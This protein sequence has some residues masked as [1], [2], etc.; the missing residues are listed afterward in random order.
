ML[1]LFPLADDLL[2]LLPLS[3]AINSAQRHILIFRAVDMLCD[4]SEEN[5][6]SEFEKELAQGFV[7]ALIY[8]FITNLHI[9]RY[10]ADYDHMNSTSL[11]ECGKRVNLD[12]VKGVLPKSTEL[13]TNTREV[14]NWQA[15][16]GFGVSIH[17][18]SKAYFTKP[19]LNEILNVIFSGEMHK[20]LELKNV[21][22]LSTNHLP[23][24][25][26]SIDR[27]GRTFFSRLLGSTNHTGNINLLSNEPFP[28]NVYRL[29]LYVY[30]SFSIWNKAW[31]HCKNS[32]VHNRSDIRKIFQIA[33]MNIKLTEQDFEA[34]LNVISDFDLKAR[35]MILGNVARTHDNVVDLLISR[36]P[37]ASAP[38]SLQIMNALIIATHVNRKAIAEYLEV[39]SNR[40]KYPHALEEYAL[41]EDYLDAAS[42]EA[43]ELLLDEAAKP[44]T[45]YNEKPRWA[46]QILDKLPDLEPK[47]QIYLFQVLQGTQTRKKVIAVSLIFRNRLLLEY[48]DPSTKVES[49]LQVV[50]APDALTESVKRI[51]PMVETLKEL[52]I[53]LAVQVALD[54][55]GELQVKLLK[56]IVGNLIKIDD[57]HFQHLNKLAD[58]VEISKSTFYLSERLL[59]GQ[60]TCL[61]AIVL[62][63]PRASPK[64]QPEVES[65]ISSIRR[66]HAEF[67]DNILPLSFSPLI[68]LDY[69]KNLMVKLEKRLS[70]IDT[71][72][73]SSMQRHVSAT[74][75][76]YLASL[77]IDQN[78]L[79]SR[80]SPQGVYMADILEKLQPRVPTDTP[81]NFL[82]Y[83]DTNKGAVIQVDQLHQ[84]LQLVSKTALN[85]QTRV[86]LCSSIL[87]VSAP[88]LEFIA[89]DYLEK[90]LTDESPLVVATSL[91]VINELVERVSGN[92][93]PT[94]KSR[95]IATIEEHC[96]RSTPKNL[97]YLHGL[98]LL[99]IPVTSISEIA[100]AVLYRVSVANEHKG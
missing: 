84:L 2:A 26:A 99:G 46:L 74:Q 32:G 62:K 80:V 27:S 53:V 61:A 54:T 100:H 18:V 87:Q 39:K 22:R 1:N 47:A 82:Q 4:L 66:E 79:D 51:N 77:R 55:V 41:I 16:Y 97:K 23:A 20:L 63:Y 7:A 5:Y 19:Y 90:H 76:G 17:K 11:V 34:F 88:D 25:Q 56:K 59:R 58:S 8:E 49:L 37:S 9:H 48:V 44:I 81:G 91:Y 93:N 86:R 52:A 40:D 92:I 42:K 89:L 33:A 36:L 3:K 94:T 31:N 29:F 35:Y 10:L 73:L 21:D 64:V 13:P 15:S 45:E 72:Q 68:R 71:S 24:S 28:L 67:F 85:E 60:I 83:I 65:V 6:L 69:T 70:E 96:I 95:I 38:E 78:R 57:Q 14:T 98:L 43:L 12:K 50:A 75:L 30:P